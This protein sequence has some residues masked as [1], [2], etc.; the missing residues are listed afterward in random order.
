MD[1]IYYCDCLV[2][3]VGKDCIVSKNIIFLNI[4]L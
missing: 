1:G 4:K 3:L 2:F